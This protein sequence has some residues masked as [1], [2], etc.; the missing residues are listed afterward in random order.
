VQTFY[1]GLSFSLHT[2]RASF[3][4]IE[5]FARDTFAADRLEEEDFPGPGFGI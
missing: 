1:V 4:V 2:S 5:N 3:D